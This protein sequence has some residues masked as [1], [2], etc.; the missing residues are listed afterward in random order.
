ML[1]T[2]S[3]RRGMP[4]EWSFVLD[5]LQAERD[6]GITI[7][8]S[9]VRFRTPARDFVL[10]DAPGHAEFLRNMITGAAQADAAILV[11]DATEGVRDQTAAARL[12]PAPAGAAAADRGRQQD[13]PYRLRH[14]ALPRDRDRDTDLS[15]GPR[16]AADGDHPDLGARGRRH[17]RAHYTRAMV[18]ADRGRSARSALASRPAQALPLRLPV[19]AVY[20]FDE[21]RILPAASRA[22]GIA[23]DDEIVVLP[24]GAKARVRS[25][26]QWPHGKPGS[27]P[28]TAHAGQSVGITLDHALFVERGHLLCAQPRPPAA[29]IGCEP[30]SSGCMPRRSTAATASACGSAPP[31]RTA[32]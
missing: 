15:D 10:I 32:S 30:A 24:S 25:I 16:V 21:R 28:Q 9:Q 8:T 26:E 27:G 17:H 12:P 31:R 3:A 14:D 29:V 20:K 6:Q 18:S 23:V 7:D 11:I 13:G 5:A 19:Q 1:K 2:V 22:A 4:F